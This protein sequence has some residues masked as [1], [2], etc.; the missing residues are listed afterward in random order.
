MFIASRMNRL[1]TETAYAVAAAAKAY[2][3]Q[4]NKVYPFHIG[5][6][7]F[8][9]P[10]NIIDAAKTALDKGYTGYCPAAGIT[11]LRESLAHDINKSHNTDYSYENVSIQPG[12]KPVI[13]KFIMTLM[14]EGDHA[15]YPTPGYPIYES[16]INFFRGIPTPYTYKETEKGFEI[17][18][19][20][21]RSLITP[22]T[23][24]LIYNNYHNPMGVCSSKEEMAEIA[25]IAVEND[26]YVL[27]DEAYYDMVYQGEEQRSIVSYPGMK[28]RTVILYTFAKKFAMTGWRLGAAIGP[29][30]II[31]YITKINTN[32]EAC[33]C[34]FNQYAAIEAL[35]GDQ[36][37]PKEILDILY[38]RLN[39]ILDILKDCPGIIVHKPKSTFY[40]FINVTEL[41]NK[42]GINKYDEFRQHMLENTGVSFCTRN[43]FGNPL[44]NE[45][46][47][48]IRLA[49][50]GI[51]EEMIREGL[52]KFKNYIKKFF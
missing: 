17:D 3:A 7:N 1:G 37:R 35:K 20:Y 14:E 31:D 36:N 45:T 50:S 47:K 30:E 23:R 40:L 8:K 6:L 19:D 5:D 28:E 9:T 18:M 41:M 15:M 32:D 4:G 43:H 10:S 13:G 29:K 44:P 21:F 51:E 48:Y 42:M 52:T 34:H 26:L 22:K 38:N 24:V 11:E 16:E 46:N 33:T 49:Y 2:A 12:G 39:T 27:S 25:K